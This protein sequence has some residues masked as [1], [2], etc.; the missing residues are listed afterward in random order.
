LILTNTNFSIFVYNVGNIINTIVQLCTIQ[1]YMKLKLSIIANSIDPTNVTSNKLIF[2]KF[3]I[4]LYFLRLKRDDVKIIT[5][6]NHGNILI[7][8]GLIFLI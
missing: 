8:F 3:I 4:Q 6:S 2:Y 5:M 1:S 7:I